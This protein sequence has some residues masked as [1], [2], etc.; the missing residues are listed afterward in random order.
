MRVCMRELVSS[1]TLR[2]I[3]ELEILFERA[4]RMVPARVARHGVAAP[5]ARGVQVRERCVRRQALAAAVACRSTG[6]L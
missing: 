3:N 1:L 2:V 5:A 4:Q 6:A